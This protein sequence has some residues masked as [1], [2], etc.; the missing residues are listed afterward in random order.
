MVKSLSGL[1]SKE[2]RAAR[3]NKDKKVEGYRVSEGKRPAPPP[4]EVSDWD[5]DEFD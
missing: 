5:E 3:R 4:P 2:K 1:P